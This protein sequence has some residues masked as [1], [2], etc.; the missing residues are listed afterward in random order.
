LSRLADAHITAQERLRGLVEAAVTRAWAGLPGTDD[1]DVAG[2]LATVVP[3]V[4]TGQATSVALTDAYLAQALQRPPAGIVAADI[5]PGLR[6]GVGA[7]EVYRRPFVT[8]WTALKDGRRYEDAAAAALAR[9]T[10]S[11]AMDVQLASRATFQAAQDADPAIR[12]YRRVPDG[13]ACT[14]CLTVA[15]AK[16]NSAA[17]MP[18]HNRC[19]CS[20]EPIT[21]TVTPT[22]V[23]DTVAVH[24]HG[25]LGPVLADPAHD[26]TT[27]ALALS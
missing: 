3:I 18:L 6:G 11:A 8:L 20:L 12:G 17:A 26:F 10:S 13:G 22:P 24:E 23:P 7:D 19:G 15:G 9:A 2:W 5:I 4:T 21:D 14:F 16:V 1:A 25:E 27:A